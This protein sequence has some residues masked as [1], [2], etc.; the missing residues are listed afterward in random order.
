MPYI[1]LSMS[2]SK[3]ENCFNVNPSY[4]KTT[5]KNSEN[6]SVLCNSD[7]CKNIEP[8]RKISKCCLYINTLSILSN[9]VLLIIV[10]TTGV[11]LFHFKSGVDRQ[12]IKKPSGDFILLPCER[13][14][15]NRPSSKDISYCQK[16]SDQAVFNLLTLLTTEYI[17]RR[18]LSEEQLYKD[19]NRPVLRQ[20][21][22]KMYYLSKKNASEVTLMMPKHTGEDSL[23]N[24]TSLTVQS[25]GIYI[26]YV[27]LQYCF[28][29][30]NQ[31]SDYGTVSMQIVRHVENKQRDDILFHNNVHY[32]SGPL[33][34]IPENC[35]LP[36]NL[37]KGDRL[38]LHV[39][40]IQSFYETRI[41]NVFGLQEIRK[42]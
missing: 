28:R 6:N 9:I 11:V 34:F 32:G 39:T 33:S 25:D 42:Y 1:P 13:N 17:G 16:A 18:N 38:S 15:T 31:T 12:N 40:N 5:E 23:Y 29:I 22:G 10:S 2:A 8:K 4:T 36:V 20:R 21:L 27:S 7:Q 3:S 24:K 41:S 37:T 26:I 30:R 19:G 14:Y 35:L